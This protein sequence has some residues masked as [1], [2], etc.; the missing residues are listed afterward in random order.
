MRDNLDIALQE[1]AE[2]A[3]DYAFDFASQD[4]K[5]LK[6]GRMCFYPIVD[7]ENDE[8]GVGVNP[9]YHYLI[10]QNNGFASFPMKWAYGKA[11]PLRSHVL[12]DD[13]WVCMGDLHVGDRIIGSDGCLTDVVGIYDQGVCDIY[14]IE[15]YDGSHVQCTKEHLWTVKRKS[16]WVHEKTLQ[17]SDFI[18]DIENKSSSWRIRTVAP[19]QFSKKNLLIDPYVVGA[20]IGDGCLC[21]DYPIFYCYQDG[22]MDVFIEHLMGI[23]YRFDSHNEHRLC[24]TYDKP[25]WNMHGRLADGSYGS[26]TSPTIDMF[27]QIGLWGTTSMTKFIPK[28][29]MI[30]DVNDRLLL[31]QGLMDT[32]GSCSLIED[33]C[34][35]T[36]V[37][38]TLAAQVRDLVL[39]LGGMAYIHQDKRA[40]KYKHGCAYIVE[41][42]FNNG[43]VPFLAPYEKKLYRFAQRQISKRDVCRRIKHAVMVGRE[44]CRCIL[45]SNADG[46]YVTDGYVLTHNTIPMFIN[47]QLVFRKCTGINQY[48]SGYK[49]YW[50]RDAAGNL[51]SEYKQARAWVHPGLAPKNFIEDA[52]DKALEEKEDEI[53]DAIYYDNYGW[54]EEEYGW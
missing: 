38:E 31:L 26:D 32:D 41:M 23:P 43:I 24:L 8:I 14:D 4:L 34:I 11:Q 22:G 16:Q 10:Y 27:R 5:S 13:G 44:A 53:G 12:T 29:Y 33:S 40:D 19:I 47:G 50:Q 6:G 39:S 36:S 21:G 20:M 25:G 54:I 35:F 15:F 9:D 3:C 2:L 49:N 37:S 1:T 51:L 48:R 45:V 18:H 52:I 7:R 46:L 28:Q 42:R 17:L 30:S